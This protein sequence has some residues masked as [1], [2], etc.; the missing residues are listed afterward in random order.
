MH[1]PEINIQNSTSFLEP[2]ESG[3]CYRIGHFTDMAKSLF[4][5]F[6]K[7]P[8][9]WII[10]IAAIGT[11]TLAYNLYLEYLV[12]PTDETTKERDS[13]T[14]SKKYANK[15]IAVT[16]LTLVLN[17]ALPLSEILVNSEN[18]VFILPP[19]LSEED[20]VSELNGDV[21][22]RENANY[23]LLKCLNI[24]GYIAI[25][26]SLRPDMLYVCADDMGLPILN[27]T[28]DLSRFIK[29]IINIDQTSEDVYDKV[30]RIFV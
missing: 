19:N 12:G 24:Q 30:S 28:Q 2:Q 9:T 3:S 14:V 21:L 8:Q 20:L 29:Q 17:L 18:I 23:K 26:K 10:G 1:R 22:A 13:Y 4:K 16:L 6:R 11:A 5:Q 15:S 7:S 25:L 27:F